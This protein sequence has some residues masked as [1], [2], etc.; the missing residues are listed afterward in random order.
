[1]AIP[2]KPIQPN[3]SGFNQGDKQPNK[4]RMTTKKLMTIKKIFTNFRAGLFAMQ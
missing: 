2:I 4:K 1:M 3:F